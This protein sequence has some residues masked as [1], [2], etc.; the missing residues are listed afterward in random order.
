MCWRVV[1]FPAPGHA[2]SSKA[3]YKRERGYGEE[4][5]CLYYSFGIRERKGEG[6]QVFRFL[7][8]RL[9]WP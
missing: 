7:W 2:H 9:D 8:I 3:T 4:R 5:V 1:T 6:N